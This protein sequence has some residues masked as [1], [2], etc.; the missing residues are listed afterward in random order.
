MAVNADPCVGVGLQAPCFI[1]YYL[2]GYMAKVA[3]GLKLIFE[4]ERLLQVVSWH[5]KPIDLRVNYRGVFIAYGLKSANFYFHFEEIEL[6]A[7]CLPIQKCWL[8]P[9]SVEINLQEVSYCL[10][11]ETNGQRICPRRRVRKF[12]DRKGR[13]NTVKTIYCEEC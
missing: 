2:I 10:Y 11:R 7:C 6:S 4:V 9:W 12:L 5:S 1:R 13:D 8:V 3:V